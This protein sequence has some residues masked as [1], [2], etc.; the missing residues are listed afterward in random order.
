MN[1]I[2][3]IEEEEVARK[4]VVNSLKRKEYNIQSY[5]YLEDVD[6]YNKVDLIF[7]KYN[8]FIDFYY[9]E[10]IKNTYACPVILMFQKGDELQIVNGMKTNADDYVFYPIRDIEVK[11]KAS[12]LLKEHEVISTRVM[13]DGMIFELEDCSIIIGNQTIKL[14]KNEFKI[15][16]LLAQNNNR[17]FTKDNIFNTIY[18]FDSDTEIRNI[19]EYIYEI[20]KKFKKIDFNPIR[21]VWGIGYKWNNQ[22][23]EV[24]QCA[25]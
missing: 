7:L 9:V 16:K 22:W 6:T 21:T 13:I 12:Y 5:E 24:A 8:E 23:E 25:A 3:V 14:T 17:V 2:L 15:C 11:A 19:T 4:T 20:R 10:N 18:S 1:N